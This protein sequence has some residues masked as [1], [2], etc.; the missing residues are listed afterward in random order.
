MKQSERIQ[1]CKAYQTHPLRKEFEREEQEIK[2]KDPMKYFYNFI[3]IIPFI[4]IFVFGYIVFSDQ[5]FNAIMD[6]FHIRNWLAHL[7][8]ELVIIALGIANLFACVIA[9]MWSVE[10]KTD[11]KTNSKEY[12]A[13]KN[14][15]QEKG[16][17][18]MKEQ[19]LLSSKCGEEDMYGNLVCS[20]TGEHLN[21]MEFSWCQQAGNCKHCQK[22][23]EAYLGENALQ[24]WHYEFKK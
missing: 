23:A 17:Y 9:V 20:A 22:F 11:L 16:L 14:R 1:M 13:L 2:V 12:E 21:Y 24:Y 6:F 3:A 18:V 5:A 10:G 19:E 4:L 8:W 7:F 15:Y